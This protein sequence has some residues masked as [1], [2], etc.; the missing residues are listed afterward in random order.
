MILEKFKKKISTNPCKGIFSKTLDSNF[1]EAAGIAGLDFIILDMEHGPAHYDIMQNHIRA[2]IL[3]GMLP[4]VRVEGVNEHAIGAAL[5]AGALG[6]QV[7][8]IS[9]KA[10]AELAVRA[11]KY[12]P[13]GMRGVCRFVNSGSYGLI[14]K[15]T[16][17]E[18]ANDTLVIL[19]VEGVEGINN[20]D[21]ILEVD[22]VDILF[23]G[24]YDLSQSIGK[25]GEVDSPEVLKLMQSIANKAKIRNVVLGAFSDC[26]DRDNS[27]IDEGFRYIAHSVD[28]N[29]FGTAV[30]K[31][32]SDE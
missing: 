7:P 32:M 21:S 29:I 5:D 31:L 24:P 11:A 3:T 27:L 13:Y 22:G 18:K 8:N 6:V 10:E 16:Y 23:V 17:F 2:S 19:Q 15:K 9:T 12:H 25:P 14:D 26:R 30:K 4:I 1:V 20:L 28:I